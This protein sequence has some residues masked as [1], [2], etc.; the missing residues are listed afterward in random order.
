MPG[1]ELDP[2]AFARARRKFLRVFPEGFSDPTDL[3][4]ERDYKVESHRRWQ[5]QLGD[6]AFRALLAA[7][8]FREI[9][10]RALRVDQQ[11]RHGMV[12]RFEKMAL[13]DAV[14][15]GAGA[16]RF[17]KA[18][19]E[20]LHSA[21]PVA[22]RFDRWISELDRLPRRQARLVTW[23]VTT[24]FGFLAQ[25]RTHMFV[26]PLVMRRAA[27]VCGYALTY[28]SRPTSDGYLQFVSFARAVR[29]GLTDLRPRDMID[30][31]SFLWVQGSD[32][33]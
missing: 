15:T 29:R 8:E 30:L 3:E 27:A 13:R 7:G 12:F 2:R 6:A 9:A 25:P 18:L 16:A 23:P 10:T 1:A 20:F 22:A 24:V 21:S 31:Q 11:S 26:K 19:F 4:W 33:Y 28:R 17:A 5:E 32:E 14:K